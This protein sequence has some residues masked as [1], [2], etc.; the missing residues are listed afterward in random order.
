MPTERQQDRPVDRLGRALTATVAAGVLTA[1]GAMAA[2]GSWPARPQND[3]PAGTKLTPPQPPSE[4]PRPRRTISAAEARDREV[5]DVVARIGAPMPDPLA[6]AAGA[7]IVVDVKVGEINGRAVRAR[8]IFEELGPRLERAA[9]EKRLTSDDW[10]LIRGRYEAG[11]EERTISRKEWLEYAGA[12]IAVRLDA[13]LT[14]ELLEA[15]ARASLKPE[16]QQG[17]RYLVQEAGEQQRREAA[18]SRAEALR[19]LRERENKTERQF[20]REFESR[21]LIWYQLEERIRRRVRVSW[22]DMQRY[23]E[24]NADVYNPP[25]VAKFRLIRVPAG[26]PEAVSAIGAALARGEPFAEVARR[27]ENVYNREGGG[28]V[29]DRPFTGQFAAGEFFAP[30]PLNDAA[31]TLTPGTFTPE[32]IDV[33]SDKAWLYLEAIERR[34]RP[35]SDRDVQLEIARRLKESAE[36]AEQRTYLRHLKQ[37]ASFTDL[38]QMVQSLVEIAA[39]RYWPES[40]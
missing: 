4:P 40:P 23:Y 29:P 16:Q 6:P 17:L 14:D 8:E 38:E 10:R 9:A 15:E 7:P 11:M 20:L 1:C 31:R 12:L 39:A 34:S 18:G 37:R 24:R 26:N 21:V 25:P 3:P 33:G 22:R 13:M 30:G 36:L 5:L 19:R 32:P 2:D 27:A 35:L 28:Q